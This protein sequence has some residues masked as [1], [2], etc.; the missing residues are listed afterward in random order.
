MRDSPE[1]VAWRRFETNNAH[2]IDASTTCVAPG[3][4]MHGVPD[5]A[6]LLR[7]YD[8]VRKFSAEK[9]FNIPG[10]RTELLG[11]FAL[12]D[13]VVHHEKLI[14]L[15]PGTAHVAIAIHEV[16]DG[17]IR[18]LWFIPAPV[19]HKGDKARSPAQ[20]DRRDSRAPRAGEVRPLRESRTP[21]CSSSQRLRSSPP[22]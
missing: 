3:I 20:S 12:G 7:E 2:D 16:K 8:Q 19:V 6:L 4:E 17:L 13:F 18:R 9:R 10:L 5:G 15:E 22:P 1:A 21:S 11:T 14:G